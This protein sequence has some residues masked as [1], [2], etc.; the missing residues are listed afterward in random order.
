MK[1]YC[2]ATFKNQHRIRNMRDRLFL[3]GHNVL[4]TW[5]NEQVKP[6]GMT[7][8]QF[9]R[10][11]AAKDLREIQEADCVILDLADP[12]QTG[13]KLIEFGFALAHHKL[14]YTVGPVIP[15]A[16]FLS[17]ADMHFNTWDELFSYFADNHNEGDV[18]TNK[19]INI[20]Q[21]AA[22]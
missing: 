11:M 6:S 5:L 17:L 15:H 22:V 16:I 9:G 20:S 19:Y 7:E 18:D 3:L 1:I 8:E 10:K 21:K 13:G 2:A 4:S 12:S 14:L